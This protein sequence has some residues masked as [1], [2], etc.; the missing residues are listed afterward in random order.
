VSLT[1]SGLT[2]RFQRGTESVLALD[3]V[4]LELFPG[5]LVVAAGPS[6]SGKT[7]LLSI[8]A[9]LDV[10][11]AGTVRPLPPLPPDAAPADL[12]WAQLAF[13]PQSPVLLDELTIAENIDLP[14]R[15]AGGGD[16]SLGRRRPRAQDE[17]ESG[18]FASALEPADRPRP[19]VG[20]PSSRAPERVADPV[21]GYPVGQLLAELEIGQ[22]A[23]RYPSQ[24]S[25]GEQQRTAVG[26]ALRLRPRVLIAD[27]PTGHQD[28]A[29]VGLV[30]DLLRRH[31]Y[32]GYTV[33]ISSHDT[34]VIRT[35]D[36]VVTLADGRVVTD[37]YHRV[38]G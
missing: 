21:D 11:D 19:V 22:L 15:L 1:V 18:G 30:L 6:G 25:G 35:A 4:D 34:D 23:D 10:P 37:S 27:E 16:R 5:E 31:A 33:L 14:A 17:E 13:V 20:I 28:R 36:R 8:L 32:A 26:R 7:T 9:G 2:R 29:R 24:V 38:A 3:A 12:T